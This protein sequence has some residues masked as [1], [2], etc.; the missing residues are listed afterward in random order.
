MEILEIKSPTN[1]CLKDT[2]LSTDL[3]VTTPGFVRSFQCHCKTIH[4]LI[5]QM[6][7]PIYWILLWR[8][9]PREARWHQIFA[10]SQWL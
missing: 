9:L 10:R 7:M 4:V 5:Y 6:D 2:L 1:L 3:D 8:D